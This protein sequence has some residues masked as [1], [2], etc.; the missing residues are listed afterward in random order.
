MHEQ[1]IGSD[2]IPVSV[3]HAWQLGS[4]LA[5]LYWS[6]RYSS[7]FTLIS[8]KGLPISSV[9]KAIKRNRKQLQSFVIVFRDHKQENKRK[10]MFYHCFMFAI[11]FNSSSTSWEVRNSVYPCFFQS[12]NVKDVST[13][14]STNQGCLIFFYWLAFNSDMS[15]AP[16]VYIRELRNSVLPM[17]FY[18]WKCERRAFDF[19]PYFHNSRRFFFLLTGLQFKHLHHLHSH[20][21][22]NLSN[23]RNMAHE[24]FL[25]NARQ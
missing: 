25:G 13:S 17:L 18:G 4:C 22:D 14:I 11:I 5:Y 21:N 23:E 1:K 6:L 20:G 12:W 10:E 2:F 3:K 15:I 19:Y 9:T 24:T 16:V 7:L 8:S